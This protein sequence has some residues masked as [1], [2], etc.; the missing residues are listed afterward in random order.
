MELSLD[1]QECLSKLKAFLN[2]SGLD[3]KGSTTKNF[4]MTDSKEN[5]VAVL[6]YAGSGKTELLRVL[7]EALEN[8]KVNSANIDYETKLK[9]GIRCYAILAPTNK[10]VSVLKSFVANNPSP[11]TFDSLIVTPSGSGLYIICS[12]LFVYTS[13]LLFF[14]SCAT[15]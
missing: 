5:V 14:E 1:Q 13:I 7:V 15:W 10:A 11:C 9:K 12:S 2:I 8:S 4:R 3:L 6:G